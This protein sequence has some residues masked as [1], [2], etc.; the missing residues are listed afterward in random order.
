[1]DVTAW[2]LY[3]FLA[4]AALAGAVLHYR[5][6]EP[7]GRGRLVLALL[8]GSVLAV[9]V[10]LLF[11]PMLPGGR[12]DEERVVL[13]DGSL[14]MR[15]QGPDG[16]SRWEE[17]LG[18]GVVQGADRVA[19][20]GAGPAVP[21]AEAA[22]VSPSLPESRL[23][24]ALRAALESGARS[25]V[26]VTDGAVEDA[27][28]VRA[29]ASRSGGV[30]IH[31]VGGATAFNAGV[32][33]VRAPRW[34]RTGQESTLEVGVGRLGE[35]GPDSL[36]VVLRHEGR[37]LGRARV[38]TPAPG[39]LATASIAFT[40]PAAQDG[41]M[42]LE[43]VLDGAAGLA[44]DDRRVVYVEVGEEPPGVALVS[45]R[46]DQEPR[47]LLPVLERALGVPTRGWLQ[48]GSD[49]F[50]RVGT[51]TEAGRVA[52]TAEV[53]AAVA[54]AGLVVLHGLSSG[55]P[56]WARAAAREAVRLLVFPDGAV[57]G[58]PVDP[59]SV[60]PGDWYVADSLPASPVAPLLAGLD[61]EGAPPLSG[62]R[63]AEAPDGWWAPLLAREGRRGPA[64]PIV[65][66]G[67]VGGRRTA[68]VLGDGSWRWA[69]AEDG[70]R[71]L[72]DR[73]WSAIAGWLAEDASV[74]TGPVVRPRALVVPRGQPVAWVVTGAAGSR[75]S[76]E[77]EPGI[78][79]VRIEIRPA[80]GEDA[81]T[82]DTVVRPQD[83]VATTAPLPPGRYRYRARTGEVEA[84]GELTVESYTP[85]LTRP[86]TLETV[87]GAG[88][89][90]G[91]AGRR[92]GRPL[93]ASPW[94]YV[95]V[96]LALCTE[97]VLRRRWGLR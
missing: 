14:S 83:G 84:A 37:E 95:W 19:I 96:V 38:P 75:G 53:R 39:R 58:L 74:A 91:D 54:N 82:L 87:D 23:G 2:A 43:T 60:R 68:V 93:H 56:E 42:R 71:A 13:L 73:L 47:F 44:D 92:A 9:L 27:A 85:E 63:T 7:A 64:R 15:L 49:R 30:E 41:R 28:D 59:G 11:D 10:L 57:P 36:E 22:R 90:S 32:V 29:L 67:R 4:G 50:L 35:G 78:D 33:E 40:P 5:R 12:S 51:G 69:F 45:F 16:R 77:R 20:F 48:V 66:A 79:S 86:A 76:G 31:G 8:R 89:G 1:M 61:A 34:V 88:V 25:I 62:L 18:L 17:A 65:V 72:Y 6:H 97:W 24:P 46:P 3:A 94:P 55:A 26:V 81:V 21:T 80:D 70:G 52:G